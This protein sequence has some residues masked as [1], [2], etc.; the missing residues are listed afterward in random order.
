MSVA[1]NKQDKRALVLRLI[2]A[3]LLAKPGEGPL[4][5][6]FRRPIP[7][8]HS[9]RSSTTAVKNPAQEPPA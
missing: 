6:R 5:P 1:S 2:V 7:S 4:A 9:P 8:L 3:E